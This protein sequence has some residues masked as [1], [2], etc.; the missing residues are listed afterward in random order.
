MPTPAAASNS[1][2]ACRQCGHSA[3][4][5]RRIFCSSCVRSPEVEMAHISRNL[6]C[7]SIS[8]QPSPSGLAVLFLMP[9]FY[10]HIISKHLLPQLI[11]AAVVMVP[12]VSEGL[13]RLLA[14]LRQGV[15]V[16]EV[17][18]QSLTLIVRQGL[19]H[20]AKTITPKNRFCG[21]IALRGR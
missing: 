18:A 14:D 19:E 20:L 1:F 11:E 7:G 6:S 2:K 3:R 17:Q 10:G 15:T 16:K 12:H 13:S 5:P 8:D 4:C 21:I 9:L